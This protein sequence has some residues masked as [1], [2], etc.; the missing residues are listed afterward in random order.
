MK[1]RKNAG[2]NWGVGVRGGG[3]GR[4]SQFTW[5]YF[6]GILTALNSSLNDMTTVRHLPCD[7]YPSLKFPQ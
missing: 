2:F 6:S 5:S 1:K 4:K 7:R 3:T